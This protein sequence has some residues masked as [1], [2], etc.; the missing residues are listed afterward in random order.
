ML[1]RPP[2][3]TLFP[4]TT[5]FRSVRDL[6]RAGGSLGDA[7]YGGRA[8]LTRYRVVNGEQRQTELVEVDLAAA[9]RGDPAADLELQPFD[10]LSIKEL[11][12]WGQEE[13]V[14]LRGEVRF[15]GIY[16]IR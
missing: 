5:L 12:E 1:P 16:P 4:Y 11:P 15:P 2:R 3:S 6:L 8:E 14:T 13:K 10:Y 9:L 7:A